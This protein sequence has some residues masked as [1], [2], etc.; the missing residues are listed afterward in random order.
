[1][2][3][4][5]GLRQLVSAYKTPLQNVYVER[6]IGTLR[7]ECLDY[8]IVMGEEHARQILAEFATYYNEARCHASLD[9]DVPAHREVEMTGAVTATAYLGGL[10]HG[11]ARAA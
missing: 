5:L 6:L 11:Y 2:M 3:R 4:R 7:R 9:G 10:H 1:M 8:V